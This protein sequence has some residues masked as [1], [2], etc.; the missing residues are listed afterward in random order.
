MSEIIGISYERMDESKHNMSRARDAA[1]EE[2]N[3]LII[4]ES[5]LQAT[6]SQKLRS[7]ADAINEMIGKVNIRIDNIERVMASIDYAI[8]RFE[9]VDKACASRIKNSQINDIRNQKS[10]IAGT[11]V[12]V[13]SH[14]IIDDGSKSWKSFNGDTETVLGAYDLKRLEASSNFANTRN[15]N[16]YSIYFSPVRLKKLRD[17]EKNGKYID[18]YNNILGHASTGNKQAVTNLS[19]AQIKE[20]SSQL[21][22]D[23]GFWA[24]IR[25]NSVVNEYIHKI[26]KGPNFAEKMDN[27]ISASPALSHFYGNSGQVDTDGKVFQVKEGGNNIVNGFAAVAG[28]LLEMKAMG[29]GSPGGF[30]FGSAEKA[31]NNLLIKN[32][33]ISALPKVAQGITRMTANG[34]ETAGF[35]GINTMY[36]GGSGKDILN[37]VGIGFV[38]GAGVRGIGMGFKNTIPQISK[39]RKQAINDAFK[40]KFAEIKVTEKPIRVIKPVESTVTPKIVNKSPVKEI[41]KIKVNTVEAKVVGID[42]VREIPKI[43]KVGETKEATPITK[44]VI[45]PE[46]SRIDYLRAKYGKLSSGELQSEINRKELRRIIGNES[47]SKVAQSWQGTKDYPGIDNYKNIKIKESKVLYRGEPYGT[48]YFTTKSAVERSGRNAG[49]LFEGLQVMENP[50]KGYRGNMKGYKAIVDLDAAFGITKANPIY[51]GGGLPQIFMPNANELIK[52]KYLI[53][54]DN[55]RL[56]K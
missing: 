7:E 15:R 24:P 31:A 25:N 22:P 3:Q 48:E 32:K 37:S 45:K 5:V 19:I 51:G 9:E 56:N 33:G 27:V 47:P 49:D 38:M 41:G 18:S 55:I 42:R 50:I 53:P 30:G 21:E 10:P 16:D 46:I 23:K 2:K 8:R 12:G 40:Q 14:S 4:A 44:K 6:G 28:G 11:N 17:D 52:N 54:V 43:P 29:Q 20:L 36:Q 1:Q 34:V 13:F 26:F 35:S 39:I